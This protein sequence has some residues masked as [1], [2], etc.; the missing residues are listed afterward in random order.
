MKKVH[1]MIDRNSKRGIVFVLIGLLTGS[2]ITI[3]QTPKAAEMPMDIS[4][5]SLNVN[6]AGEALDFH[7][8]KW[9]TD[10]DRDKLSTVWNPAPAPAA[11]AAP[12]PAQRAGAGGRGA[13]PSPAA[14]KTP[15]G[16]LATALAT[17]PNVGYFWT[18]ETAGYLVRY[19]YRV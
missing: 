4:A 8:V 17:L 6:G 7:I 10:A 11:P 19:A 9:S 12:P 15:E 14:P 16:A 13:A 1:Q 5:T 18:S 2:V 3:A